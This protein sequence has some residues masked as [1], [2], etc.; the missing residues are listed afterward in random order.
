[1]GR[2]SAFAS[3]LVIALASSA[4]AAAPPDATEQLKVAAKAEV[5]GARAA[6]SDGEFELAIEHYQAAMAIL[7]AP[8]LHY[9]IA[10]C[11]QRLALTAEAAEQRTHQRDLAIESY[12]R[13]LQENPGADDRLEVAETIRE[14]GGSPVTM[15][16][17]KPLF[18]GDDQRA[19]DHA[20]VKVDGG[21]PDGPIAP[22]PAQ[23]RPKPPYPDNG[24]FGIIVAGGY[25]PTM[26]SAKA[27]DAPGM[28]ALDLHVG[29]FLGRRHRFL[30]AAQSMVYSGSTRQPD[31]FS[32]Y[33]Y[34]L[35]LLGQQT[36]VVG[37]EAVQI[38]FGAVAALTGQGLNQ[39]DNVPPPLCNTGAGAQI[40]S[41]SGG[42]VA[43]RL[44][45]GILVGARRRGMFSLLVQPSFAVFGDGRSGDQ[46]V[47]GETPW[48]ALNVRPRWQFQLWAGAGFGFR[49]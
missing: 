11:H 44:D 48:T 13:Y 26:Q 17:L 24:R 34:T 32:F 22:P 10:V 8:K 1:M 27:I 39:R 28:I 25:S 7:A 5:A 46:C 3:L 37:R 20:D 23:P 42:L 9:N 14:L 16:A 15:P 49:F 45:L 40:A 43:P 47:D 41:R 38:G 35:G 30:L 29:G 2:G 31:G 33:G 12:N 6:F 18:E 4:A 36:W 19:D 21:E